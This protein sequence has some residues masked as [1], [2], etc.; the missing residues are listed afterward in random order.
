MFPKL[1]SKQ[2]KLIFWVFLVALAGE[3]V[4]VE[5][6][7]VVEIVEAVVVAAEVVVLISKVFFGYFKSFFF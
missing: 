2:K 4:V 1:H 7:I 3:I 6:V 5:V